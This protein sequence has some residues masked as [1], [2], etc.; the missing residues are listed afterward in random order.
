LD[1]EE[2]D[3]NKARLATILKPKQL[4][5]IRKTY[6]HIKQVGSSSES[7]TTLAR[8]YMELIGDHVIYQHDLNEEVTLLDQAIA[9]LQ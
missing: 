4:S 2:Y 9:E 3:A 8:G 1:K 7:G 6:A 5:I